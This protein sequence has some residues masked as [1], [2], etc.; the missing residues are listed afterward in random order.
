MTHKQILIVDDEPKV[1]FFLGRSLKLA[2]QECEVNTAK[3]GEEALEI[4]NRTPVDL[5]I[6]DLR[7]PGISGLDLIR[8]V[9]AASPQTRTILITAYGNDEIQSEARNL[10]VYRYITKPFNVHQ[11]TEVVQGALRDVAVSTPGFTVFSD[12]TFEAIARRLET[13]RYDTGARCIL[14]ADRQGQLLVEVGE[15]EGVNSTL[16]LALLAGGFAASAEL[17][18]QFGDGEAINL[19]FQEGSRY[20]IYSANVGDNLFVALVY[21]RR[22]QKSRVGMVWLY[23]RRA[24][25]ELAATFS[26]GQTTENVQPLD[27]DFSSSLLAELDSAFAEDDKLVFRPPAAP[28]PSRR[29]EPAPKPAPPSARAAPP[30]PVQEA[31]AADKPATGELF[32]LEEAVKRGLIPPNLLDK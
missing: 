31:E 10:E 27:D 13:L 24:I 1:A 29:R 9:S 16:L 4:L 14:L 6:T 17:A 28:S 2:D 22:I 25:D 5:L 18:R 7:M 12:E 15:T 23:V 3:S 11:F 8:W 30:P 26:A 21:D 20:D 32:S 19:N